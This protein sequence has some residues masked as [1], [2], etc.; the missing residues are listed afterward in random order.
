M[1]LKTQVLA[2]LV[3]VGFAAAA[4]SAAPAS[5]PA[6][7]KNPRVALETSKGKIVIE[8]E[9]TKAPK[10]TENFLSYVRAGFYDGT[11]FHRV[12]PDFMVQGGAFKTDMTQKQSK[13]PIR[14]EADNGLK[15]DKYTVAMARTNDPHSGSSQ[16]F[17]NTKDN[18][19]LNFTAQS[20]Q[21]WGYA[22]F[23][24]VVEGFD[25]VDAI[26]KTP[27]TTKK[28]FQDVPVDAVTV[29]KATVLK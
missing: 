23:G 4:A 24:K 7:A 11:I 18:A 1:T 3:L 15:N 21:G 5:P 12:I 20:L 2:S 13:A 9:A 29:K 22:V 26:G 17:I 28:G 10:S 19:F 16:F 14:N 6:R 8:L 27:T 25:V